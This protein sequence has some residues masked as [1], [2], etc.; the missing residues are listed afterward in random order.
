M[1]K[2]D[3]AIAFN[4]CINAQD[5]QGLRKLMTSNHKFIDSANNTFE[6]KEKALETWSGFFSM[7]PEYKNVF[8][9]VEDKG[10]KVIMIGH[11]VCPNNTEL[12]APRYGRQE[13]RMTRFQNG[14][15]TTM[16]QKIGNVWVLNS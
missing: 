13:L 3:I 10:D 12:D 9:V 2:K 7:F 11:S 4:E 5:L 6:G 15:Y 14:E 8:D 1:S 16:R